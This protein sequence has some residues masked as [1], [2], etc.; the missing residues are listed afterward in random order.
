[1]P[2]QFALL[3]R[4]HEVFVWSDGLLDRVEDL[5]LDQWRT[6]CCT[7]LLLLLL[8]LPINDIYIKKGGW[9]RWKAGPGVGLGHVSVASDM[10]AV[11][12]RHDEGVD[13]LLLYIAATTATS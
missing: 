11:R 5:F 8:V 13:N 7:S 1:M 3:D 12:V 2:L 9:A 10:G 4:C 6:Y